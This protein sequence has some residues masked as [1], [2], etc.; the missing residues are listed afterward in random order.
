MTA[1]TTYSMAE[2]LTDE[3]SARGVGR[4]SGDFATSDGG[5]DAPGSSAWK[6]LPMRPNRMAAQ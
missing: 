5:W 2:I 1:A 6:A 3:P 4:T